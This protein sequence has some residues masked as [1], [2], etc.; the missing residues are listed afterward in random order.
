MTD[1]D[2]K[3]LVANDITQVICK[4]E[5]E[6]KYKHRLRNMRPSIKTAYSQALQ[7][8]RSGVGAQS[9]RQ[10]LQLPI[11]SAMA[12]LDKDTHNSYSGLKSTARTFHSNQKTIIDSSLQDMKQIFQATTAS[13]LTKA[14]NNTTV[15][16]ALSGGLAQ[17]NIVAHQTQLSY[18]SSPRGLMAQSQFSQKSKRFLNPFEKKRQLLIDQN[19][20]NLLT[21]MLS[22]VNRKNKIIAESAIVDQRSSNLQ[23]TSQ[24]MQRY[25]KDEIN[26]QNEQIY[27][28]L[29]SAGPTYTLREWDDHSNQVEKLRSQI[30]QNERRKHQRDLATKIIRLKQSSMLT[31]FAIKQSTTLLNSERRTQLQMSPLTASSKI[32]SG[33]DNIATEQDGQYLDNSSGDEG[34]N[35]ERTSNKNAVFVIKS[36]VQT[37]Q[38]IPQIKIP[39]YKSPPRERINV[40]MELRTPKMTPTQQLAPLRTIYSPTSNQNY[41]RIKPEESVIGILERGT[42]ARV[43]KEP[44]SSLL[45][46]NT[47]GAPRQIAE[48]PQEK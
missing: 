19:N 18:A 27:Q 8:P 7:T 30:N 22:I 17:S 36:Q 44:I 47:L 43:K 25:K 10:P 29:K 28:M 6:K 2:N 21:K 38:A 3:A 48:A 46:R 14:T 5:K 26:S 11:Q 34:P 33:K 13:N 32:R 1:F 31:S 39:P 24:R 15:N 23:S 9:Y 45:D 35:K 16:S 42:S 41:I 4:L 37:P 20:E 40:N 12:A